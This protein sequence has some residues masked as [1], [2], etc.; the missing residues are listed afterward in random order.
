MT[1]QKAYLKE[2]L[3]RLFEQKPQDKIALEEI[4]RKFA[5]AH[6]CSMPRNSDILSALRQEMTS[7]QTNTEVT[8]QA[9]NLMELLKIR[10]VRT[11]SGVT[12]VAIF[13]KPYPCPGNCIYCPDVKQVPKSYLPDE[14]AVMRAEDNNYNP[15]LQI[16]SRLRQ[17]HNIGHPTDKIDLIIKG[18]TWSAYSH[19]YQEK[20]IKEC[21]KVCNRRHF[22]NDGTITIN[23]SDT[24]ELGLAEV[25]KIN[26]TAKHRIIS[27]NIETRPD[28]ISE[29]EIDRLRRLG[30]TKVEIGVQTLDDRILKLCCR[31]HTVDDTVLATKLLKDA[32]FKVGYHIMPNLPGSTPQKDLQVFKMLFSDPRFQPDMLKIYPCLVTPHTELANWVKKG[33]YESYAD[34]ELV[35]LLVEVKKLI[36]GYVRIDRLGRDIP[37]KNIIAGF[38]KSNLRQIIQERMHEESKHCQCIRCQ[39]VRDTK[40][41]PKDLCLKRKEYSASGGKE[42]FLWYQSE[43]GFNPKTGFNPKSNPIGK[44][45]AL[46]R[47]RFTSRGEAII[48][49]LHTYGISTPVSQKNSDLTQHQ[50]LGKKLILEAEKICRDN[51]LIKLKI[52]SGVGVRN[53]YRNLGYKLRGTYMYKEF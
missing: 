4:K 49:E 18:G 14:P 20:F 39:E 15:Q 46:L 3:T 2:I 13:T 32:G 33:Q 29:K 28:L 42:V 31:G 53:Y 41:E 17:Y 40:F 34:N 38:K 27:I 23:I 36:P 44:L 7:F 12:P 43:I 16:S 30:V 51:N 48:R 1:S 22:S 26:E 11:L 25:Q 5:R 9:K 50:G 21:F 35:E 24:A 8:E 45:Y 6:Q 19:A 47:L 37:I 52:I 10:K